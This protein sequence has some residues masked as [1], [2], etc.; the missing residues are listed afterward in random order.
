MGVK[1]WVRERFSSECPWP[2]M[3]VS[4]VSSAVAHPCGKRGEEDPEA[5]SCRRSFVWPCLCGKELCSSAA[6]G[7]GCAQDGC[8]PARTACA[9]QR[10]FC[11][12]GSHQ[13]REETCRSICVFLLFLG[14]VPLCRGRLCWCCGSEMVRYWLSAHFA[15]LHLEVCWGF[16]PDCRMS[17]AVGLFFSKSLKDALRLIFW[18]LILDNK[19]DADCDCFYLLPCVRRID[20]LSLFLPFLLTSQSCAVTYTALK[21]NK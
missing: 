8:A 13:G 16:S 2:A 14:L 10:C 18:S 11:L 19:S 21:K 4:F 6:E 5:L 17:S 1:S 20:S 7:R 3:I 12:H 15:E 9:P